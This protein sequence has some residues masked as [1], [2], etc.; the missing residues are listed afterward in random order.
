MAHE[1][2]SAPE[3][4]SVVAP[5]TRT[6]VFLLVRIGT[7]GEQAVKDLLADL[8]GLCRTVGF[9]AQDGGL[10]CVAGIGSAAWDRLYGGP[11]PALLHELPVFE[12]A[13]HTSVTTD[14]DVLF[15]LRAER[16]DL[17]FELE[18]LIMDRLRGV[19]T[20]VDEVHG[21][22]YFDARDVLGF[23][24][25]TENPTGRGAAAAVFVDDDPAFDGGSYV[26][27]QKYLHDMAAWNALS[28]EQQELAIG[29]R[30]LSD[31]ELSDEEKPSNAHIALN[32]IT[33]ENGDEL[34][35]LRE[36]MPF[37]RPGHDE[38]GTLFI[39]YCRTPAVIERMLENMF[40]GSPP[41]NHDR[42]LDFSTALTGA[43][44]YVPTV[45]FLEDP[46]DFPAAPGPAATVP[47]SP[48]LG[49]GSLR[50]STR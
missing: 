44:F 24:D 9:R 2:G 3:P 22:R 6:A 32:V 41:G 1:G 4:Q 21:F 36:N 39:G 12:G 30:K 11:R 10:T 33:D 35:I 13:R 29:R 48:S 47:D 37:G 34:E 7:G 26:V 18:T 20:V 40:V 43:L 14:A 38:F 19:V 5:L 23:V 50:R 17:C 25:G 27:V 15:H 49:I 31:L 28:T 42:I 46:P 16:M 8:S 45:D